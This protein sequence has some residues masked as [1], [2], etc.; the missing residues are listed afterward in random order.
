MSTCFVCTSSS[1]VIPTNLLPESSD[2][3]TSCSKQALFKKADDLAV[4]PQIAARGEILL[5]FD[6]TTTMVITLLLA[7][8]VRDD[9]GS[10]QKPI[11]SG[12]GTKLWW[13]SNT[14]FGIWSVPPG[15]VGWLELAASR[16]GQKLVNCACESPSK[17]NWF[18]QRTNRTNGSKRSN[19][20]LIDGRASNHRKKQQLRRRAVLQ[21]R[22]DSSTR[23]VVGKQSGQHRTQFGSDP[24]AKNDAYRGAH[25]G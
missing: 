4:V 13:Q 23:R 22:C 15:A 16:H 1:N 9:H 10:I 18:V 8:C 12:S 19:A 7:T 3:L 6:Q 17:R 5:S 11:C 21:A 14:K 25:W 20:R 2:R 24:I